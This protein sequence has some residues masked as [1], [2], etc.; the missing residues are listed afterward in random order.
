MTPLIF[1]ETM[2]TERYLTMQQDE[3][4]TVV[5]VWEKIEDLNFMHDCA[6]PHFA[7]VV[8]EWLNEPYP[9][10]WLNRRGR[11]EVLIY[12]HATFLFGVL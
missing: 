4:W 1:R 10:R 3:V 6:I 9:M 12:D 8:G 5:N 2:N 7:I 11:L